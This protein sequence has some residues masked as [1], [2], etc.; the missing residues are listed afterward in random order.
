MVADMSF[1]LGIGGLTGLMTI[2]YNF[3]NYIFKKAKLNLERFKI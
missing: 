2:K 3:T 1:E